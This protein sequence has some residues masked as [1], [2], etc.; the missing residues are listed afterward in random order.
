MSAPPAP[1]VPVQV[2]MAPFVPTVSEPTSLPDG[3]IGLLV[4]CGLHASRVVGKGGS[5]IAELMTQTGAALRVTRNS[6][7]CEI[8]G[9]PDQVEHAKRLVLEIVEDGDTRDL[10][11]AVSQALHI[12][13]GARGGL[14]VA[15]PVV[16]RVGVGVE[17]M[18]SDVPASKEKPFQPP[19]VTNEFVVPLSLR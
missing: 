19:K 3:S 13:D 2:G 5:K 15:E 16:G 14:V 1:D 4:N 7:L 6:G 9:T 18:E 10:R 11:A 17:W 8:C 12:R